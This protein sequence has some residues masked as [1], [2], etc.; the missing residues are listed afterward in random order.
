MTLRKTSLIPRNAR[1]PTR[2]VIKY[3]SG[4]AVFFSVKSKVKAPVVINGAF[5]NLTTLPTLAGMKHNH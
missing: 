2:V 1:L 4:H 3:S 5:K